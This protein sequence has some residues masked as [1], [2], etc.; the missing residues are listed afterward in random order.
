MEHLP[1]L[2]EQRGELEVWCHVE[3]A[4]LD[5]APEEKR[6]ALRSGERLEERDLT[7]RPRHRIRFEYAFERGEHATINGLTDRVPM[8]LWELRADR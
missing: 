6:R 2:A 8:E 4:H 5:A 3:D 7:E 1:N